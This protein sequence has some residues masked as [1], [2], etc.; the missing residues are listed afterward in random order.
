MKTTIH[1]LLLTAFLGAASLPAFAQKDSP[2]TDGTVYRLTTVR[3]GANSQIEYLKQLDQYW[4]PS[5][6]KA[7]QAGL[8][9]DFHILRSHAAN[10][11]DYDILMIVEFKNLAALDPDPELDAKWEALHES[12]RPAGGNEQQ[13]KAFY[14][15]LDANRDILG[16]KL[17]RDQ[18]HK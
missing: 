3:T 4:Y 15:A 9:E 16:D 6:V 2:F 10:A 1:I 12:M 5:M 7:K 14:T 17:L 13:M 18:V 11:Q 8:I